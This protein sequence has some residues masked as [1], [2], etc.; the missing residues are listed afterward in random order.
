[1]SDLLEMFFT[2]AEYHDKVERNFWFEGKLI[3]VVKTFCDKKK[4]K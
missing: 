1:M 4:A 3:L 2:R